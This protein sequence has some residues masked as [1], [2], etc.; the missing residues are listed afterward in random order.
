MQVAILDAC[1]QPIERCDAQPRFGEAVLGPAQVCN[2]VAGLGQA[3]LGDEIADL[4]ESV[5]AVISD[6]AD[7]LKYMYFLK[8]KTASANAS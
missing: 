6:G 2:L 5:G 3:N 8:R 7:E 4:S 1:P